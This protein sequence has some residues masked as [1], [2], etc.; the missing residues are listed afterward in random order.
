MSIAEV[1][2]HSA[3]KLR[4]AF[5]KIQRLEGQVNMLMWILTIAAGVFA[6][7]FL[8]FLIWLLKDVPG[9]LLSLFWKIFSF[10]LFDYLPS[11]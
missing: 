4:D 8:F 6:V 3:E 9:L 1:Q 10:P 7:L 2:S 11:I 5:E